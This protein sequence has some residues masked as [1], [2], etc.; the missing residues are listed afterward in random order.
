MI[1]EDHAAFSLLLMDGS[2]KQIIL[3]LDLCRAQPGTDF[4]Q[5]FESKM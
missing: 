4:P 2:D 5:F 3:N 1:A